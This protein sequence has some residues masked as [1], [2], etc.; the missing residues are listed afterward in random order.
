MGRFRV[1]MRVRVRVTL[2]LTHTLTRSG[3]CPRT[4]FQRRSQDLALRRNRVQQR[5]DT[6]PDWVRAAATSTSD[7]YPH[8]AMKR[9]RRLKCIFKHLCF[10]YTLKII[11]ILSFSG[12]YNIVVNHVITPVVGS[13][14]TIANRSTIPLG[15]AGFSF[16]QDAFGCPSIF[17]FSPS[18][19]L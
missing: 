4:T 16:S 17:L 14:E 5:L 3:P 1:R 15:G 7:R 2:T 19:A 9:V 18:I 11:N 13:K 10:E 12:F 8:S 6:A